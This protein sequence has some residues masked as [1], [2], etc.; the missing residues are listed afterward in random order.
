MSQHST[1]TEVLHT[2]GYR[3]TMQRQLVWDTL[4]NSRKHLSADEVLVRIRKQAPRFNLAT[5][6]RS[7]EVLERLGLVK[8]TRI[9]DRA[10]YE[11]ADAAGDHYHLHCDQCGSTLDI[12]GEHLAPILHHITEDHD[13]VVSGA[14]LLVHGRCAS[15]QAK[16]SR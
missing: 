15:C 13:F 7:L 6:Y 2:S 10:Q 12:E 9:G 1:A 5:V 3:L 14:D 8:E 4:R 11:L 16:A